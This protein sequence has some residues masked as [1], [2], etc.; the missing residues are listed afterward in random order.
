MAS[1]K[2]LK[3]FCVSET[4]QVVHPGT[5]FRVSE[6][7]AKDYEKR[8]LAVAIKPVPQAAEQ[9]SIENKAAAQGPLASPGG[10]TG[11]VLPPLSSPADPAPRKRRS[12]TTEDAL[13]L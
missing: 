8:G 4:K 13:D 2:A 3:A 1:M 7:T 12:K 5:E 10:E 6:G 9:P 11:A